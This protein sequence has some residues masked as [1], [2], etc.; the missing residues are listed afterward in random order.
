MLW[1]EEMLFEFKKNEKDSMGF[2]T[3]TRYDAQLFGHF[4]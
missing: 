2:E 3:G 1:F 4:S